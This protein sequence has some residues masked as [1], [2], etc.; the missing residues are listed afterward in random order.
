M[1]KSKKFAPLFLTK[2]INVFHELD[3]PTTGFS[4]TSPL[5][6]R[7]SV[8]IHLD[9]VDA[10]NDVFEAVGKTLNTTDEKVIRDSFKHQS[11]GIK[12]QF[13]K[14]EEKDMLTLQ[15]SN[16]TQPRLMCCGINIPEEQIAQIFKNK[17]AFV[18][19]VG[20]LVT[21][22]NGENSYCTLKVVNLIGFSVYTQR[23]F[24]EN[25]N[26]DF[27]KLA[28]DSIP[29]KTIYFTGLDDKSIP[30]NE[31]DEYSMS[32]GGRE[33]EPYAMIEGSTDTDAEEFNSLTTTTIV[34][35]DELDE[36]L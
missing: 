1:N 6:Y 16:K 30:F 3:A 28:Q 5:M 13:D 20:I 15:T 12:I 25:D 23:T 35:V 2:K 18:G 8:R 11:S 26:P 29:N 24:Y 34:N 32:K 27:F 4:N 36:V 22:D 10:I 33:S 9:D 7:S 21:S 31:L 14:M 17:K 19:D